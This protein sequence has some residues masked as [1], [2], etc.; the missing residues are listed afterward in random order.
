MNIL[1]T[2]G[3]GFIGSNIFQK[4]KRNHKIFI[5]DKLTPNFK[6]KLIKGDLNQKKKIKINFKKK[7]Y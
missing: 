5:Y 3:S 7:K 2:G 4:L 6:A 1:I